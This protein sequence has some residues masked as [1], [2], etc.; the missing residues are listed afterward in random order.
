MCV[1]IYTDI[2][3]HICI[4]S[5]G[6]CVCVCVRDVC[7]FWGQGE[8][9]VAVGASGCLQLGDFPLDQGSR[10]CLK[11]GLHWFSY[12]VGGILRRSTTGRCKWH[13]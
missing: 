7:S 6:E 10:Q 4:A 11:F 8:F 3:I 5:F 12:G 2:Q 13:L 1:Y 9:Q